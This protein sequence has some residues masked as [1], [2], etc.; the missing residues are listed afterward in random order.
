YRFGARQRNIG[1]RI[2]YFF[3]NEGFVESVADA[4]I[5]E[6][7]MGSDHCPVSIELVDNF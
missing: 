1:W 7:V 2:D 6:D 4:D 3:V 5:H